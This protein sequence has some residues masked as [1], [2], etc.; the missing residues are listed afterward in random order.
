[1]RADARVQQD[2]KLSTHN[3]LSEPCISISGQP[4]P[5]YSQNHN[6]PAYLCKTVV[7]PLYRDEMTCSVCCTSDV[8]AN[9]RN[10]TRTALLW[11]FRDSDVGYKTTYLLTYRSSGSFLQFNSFK[12]AV[13]IFVRPA[14]V[15]GGAAVRTEFLFHKTRCFR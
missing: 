7:L 8:L 4:R 13:E 2:G 12:Q 11:R 3:Y 6:Q 9:R 15:F 5:T 10:I 14:T 1:M